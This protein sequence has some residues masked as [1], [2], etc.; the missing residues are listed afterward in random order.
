MRVQII[1]F[2]ATVLVSF[3]C[4]GVLTHWPGRAA[5]G[6]NAAQSNS[7]Q[8]G[9]LPGFDLASL[10]R[11]FKPCQDF[12][13]FASGGWMEKNPIPAAFSRW[14][15]FEQLN[16]QNLEVLH[17]VLEGLIKRKDLARGSRDQKIAVFY[18]SCMDET[19][20]EREGLSPLKPE[21]ER[22]AQMRS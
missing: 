18:A 6:Q 16:T 13:Q 9:S 8:T 2:V 5:S 4:V 17:S 1:R 7:S 14:G 15:R 12:N 20:I 21:L 3:L 19:T 22:I 11:S 10:N